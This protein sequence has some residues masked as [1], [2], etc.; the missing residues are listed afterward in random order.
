MSRPSN[1]MNAP[2]T[3][4]TTESIAITRY[5]TIDVDGL[6]LFYRESGCRGPFA[7]RG[8]F[9]ARKPRT[10]D[11]GHHPRLPRPQ[12]AETRPVSVTAHFFECERNSTMSKTILITGASSGFGRIT[13]EALARAGHT[14]FASMRDPTA[15]NRLHA[16]GLRQQGIAVVELDIS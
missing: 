11:R 9:R 16:Q 15:K 8:S 12:I 6:K 2:V 10:R 7:R 4:A 14:V 1:A 13:A 5:R 3:P